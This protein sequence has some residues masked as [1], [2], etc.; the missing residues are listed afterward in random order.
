MA[1]TPLE[2]QALQKRQL[3]I[4]GVLAEGLRRKRIDPNQLFVIF[5]LLEDAVDVQELSARLKM[6]EDIFPILKEVNGQFGVAA[7]NDVE[8]KVA[9]AVA[10]I[11]KTDPLKAAE[12][13]KQALKKDLD[14]DKLVAQFPELKN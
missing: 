3:V 2:Q 13:S 8:E 4:R 11:A 10:K 7:R 5:S 6:F 9:K 14:W 12:I 1:T